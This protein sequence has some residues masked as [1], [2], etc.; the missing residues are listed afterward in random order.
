MRDLG[1]SYAMGHLGLGTGNQPLGSVA[2]TAIWCSLAAVP[3]AMADTLSVDASAALVTP[4]SVSSGAPMEFGTLTVPQAGECTY[5]I[6]P[7]GT[8]TA[9]GGADCQR[10]SGTPLPAAFI[11]RCAADALVTFDV[12]YTN[13]APAGATFGAPPTPVAVDA[14]TPGA[15]FQTHPCDSDGESTVA[16][17]GQLTVTPEASDTSLAV[18]G[19][20]TLEASY[21]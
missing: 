21:E 16:A 10:L 12:R 7:V 9:T 2:L 3:F 14:R 8:F 17:G 19:T 11:V 4:L 13:G 5:A 15:L 18:V 1:Q 20:V 6:A